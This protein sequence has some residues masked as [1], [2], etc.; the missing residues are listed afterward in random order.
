M[1]DPDRYGLDLLEPLGAVA[2]PTP[3]VLNRVADNLQASPTLLA[4]L[5]F[6]H[7]ALSGGDAVDTQRLHLPT[8]DLLVAD[9]PRRSSELWEHAV[10]AGSANLQFKHANVQRSDLGSANFAKGLRRLWC[11]MF[12]RALPRPTPHPVVDIAVEQHA[13]GEPRPPLHRVKMGTL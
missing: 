4:S 10:E 6:L 13:E 8:R 12:R 5:S 9:C 11:H 2:P 7:M 1:T 3:E